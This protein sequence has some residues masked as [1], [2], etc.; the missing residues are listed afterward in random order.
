MDDAIAGR[1]HEADGALWV[2]LGNAATSFGR[3][4]MLVHEAAEVLRALAGGRA[5]LLASIAQSKLAAHA[6]RT[7][8]EQM[9]EMHA[10]TALLRA[11]V[12]LL[13]GP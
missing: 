10:A 8:A 1:W 4:R 6:G 9:I 5:D 13:L 3:E 7:F 12:S 11:H 2:A